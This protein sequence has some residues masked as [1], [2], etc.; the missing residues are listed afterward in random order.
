MNTE[1]GSLWLSPQGSFGINLILTWDS[2]RL[3]Q[4]RLSGILESPMAERELCSGTSRAREGG[5]RIQLALR[6]TAPGPTRGRVPVSLGLPAPGAR[7]RLAGTIRLGF[8]FLWA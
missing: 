6:A 7:S 5:G 8:G 3:C 1:P 2:S 4:A